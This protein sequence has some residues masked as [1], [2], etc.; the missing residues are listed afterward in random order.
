MEW[1]IQKLCLTDGTH[2]RKP[3]RER[4]RVSGWKQY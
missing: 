4:K 3:V 1:K 2:K